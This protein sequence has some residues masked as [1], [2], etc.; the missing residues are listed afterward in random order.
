V[1]ADTGKVCI[2]FFGANWTA[3]CRHRFDGSLE[4]VFE[5]QEEVASNV[6]GAIE[7]ELQAA[8]TARSANRPTNDLTSYDLHRA[9][10][11]PQ[12]R[13]EFALS[14]S[15]AT[16][17]LVCGKEGGEDQSR[18]ARR[19]RPFSQWGLTVRNPLSSSGESGELPTKWA[20]DGL[21]PMGSPAI[22]T[23]G[24][25]VVAFFAACAGTGPPLV[26][27]TS[28]WAN[29]RANLDHVLTLI[30]ARKTY[31]LNSQDCAKLEIFAQPA[32]R[33][34]LTGHSAQWMKI[35]TRAT[36]DGVDATPTPERSRP[37]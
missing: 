2:V 12:E 14:G 13:T 10:D 22:K 34:R 20:N 31:P 8:E 16:R 3:R 6:A 17:R 15:L 29:I 11:S 1:P 7:P 37:A 28:T 35:E 32:G 33:S 5:L 26:R 4:D 9:P 24:I 25:V 30:A 36:P 19:I 27:I 21:P 18:R 23:I